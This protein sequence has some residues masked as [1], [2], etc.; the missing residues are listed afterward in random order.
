MSLNVRIPQGNDTIKVELTIKEAIAL[1][2]GVRFN[3]S[4][5]TRLDA[6]AKVRGSLEQAML[7]SEERQWREQ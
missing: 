1:C 4:G 6:L 2:T 7:L 3:D 5:Q